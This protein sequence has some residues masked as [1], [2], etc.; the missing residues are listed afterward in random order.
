MLSIELTGPMQEMVDAIREQGGRASVSYHPKF[1]VTTRRGWGSTR[2]RTFEA[3][4]QRG[5]LVRTD[6]YDNIGRWWEL[7]DG[8]NADE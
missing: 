6:D 7:V 5:V 8:G 1:H 3:L 4:V 2:S